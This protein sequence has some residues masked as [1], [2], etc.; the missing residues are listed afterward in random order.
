M[1]VTG[2]VEDEDLKGEN[3]LPENLPAAGPDTLDPESEDVVKIEILY[4]KTNG[5]L[6]L[7]TELMNPGAVVTVLGALL[8]NIGGVIAEEHNQ[9]AN[10][11]GEINKVLATAENQKPRIVHA[12]SIPGIGM[13]H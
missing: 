8:N 13:P 7:N 2:V 3:P 12:S 1:Q 11:Q 9:F 10:L 6:A 5:H 4:N